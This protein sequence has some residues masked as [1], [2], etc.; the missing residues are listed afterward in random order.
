MTSANNTFSSDRDSAACCRGYLVL[1]K[2]TLFDL[3]PIVTACFVVQHRDS[4]PDTLDNFT[5]MND[6]KHGK[7]KN[8][9][10]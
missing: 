6:L 2:G 7:F 5:S 9:V 3:R 1:L 10:K 8:G 4:T